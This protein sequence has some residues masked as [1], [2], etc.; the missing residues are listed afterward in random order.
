MTSFATPT[1]ES[2]LTELQVKK[3]VKVLNSVEYLVAGIEPVIAKQAV[4]NTGVKTEGIVGHST[5]RTQDAAN[6]HALQAKV[7]MDKVLLTWSLNVARYRSEPV[8]KDG[9]VISHRGVGRMPTRSSVKMAEHIGEN[10]DWLAHYDHL[11]S[12]AQKMYRDILRV[13]SAVEDVFNSGERRLDESDDR[14]VTQRMRDS[15]YDEP[16]LL[17][18]MYETLKD[19]GF[20]DVKFGTVCKAAERGRFV[21]ADTI[22]VKNRERKRYLPSVVTEYY[23]NKAREDAAVMEGSEKD[24][25]FA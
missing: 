4:I 10:L 22:M 23:E 12:D 21:S 13:T 9:K 14:T 17:S 24:S 19:F 8:M 16:M 25:V 1:A 7:D 6:V 11:G 20:T 15:D 5:A 3:L 18:E 2:L